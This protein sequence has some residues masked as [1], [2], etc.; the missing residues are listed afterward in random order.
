MNMPI[1]EFNV[2]LNNK[3]RT[4]D[5]FNINILQYCSINNINIPRFCFHETLSIAGNCRMCLVEITGN[6][7][8]IA[9]CAVL[10]QK[11]MSIHTDTK[12][13]KKAREGVL[14]FLLINHPLDCPICDQGG[15][16]DLQDQTL[17][18]GNDKGRF[19]DFK[20]SIKDKFCGYFIKTIMT[21]CI[22]CTRCVRFLFEIAGVINFGMIGRGNTIE[23]SQYIY[24]SINSELSGNI[25]DL[26][27]VGALTSK[28]YAFVARSWELF[29]L[30]TIDIQ[31]T[32]HVNI[33]LDLR[34]HRILRVLPCYIKDLNDNFISDL[35]RFSYDGFYSNRIQNPLVKNVKKGS[36][37]KSTWL[38][39][40]KTLK[41]M[42]FKKINCFLG[43]FLDSETCILLKFFLNSFG[44]YSLNLTD[45]F[46]QNLNCDFRHNFI[47]NNSII[48]DV[49]NSSLIVLFINNLRVE[50]PILNMKLKKLVKVRDLKIFTLGNNFNYN[51]FHFNLG[52]SLK[53]FKN[54]SE[55]K[56][57]LSNLIIKNIHP[58]YFLFD[59]KF[60][61]YFFN[62]DGVFFLFNFFKKFNIYSYVLN[63]S[64][65]NLLSNEFN[66]KNTINSFNDLSFKKIIYVDDLVYF[67][68]TDSTV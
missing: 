24:K 33:R 13:V 2:F 9:A 60:L 17:I 48:N 11:G 23:I 68:N 50:N 4:S 26:C 56:N 44:N 12:L 18:Y 3:P 22:Q 28:P 65:T 38:F 42:C 66:L 35:T 46:F 45:I 15:E 55:G 62:S 14:E 7:K 43:N 37:L 59:Y 1:K 54:I 32:Y 27:P 10:L 47:I 67:L 39:I 52:N 30:H 41:T 8:P 16:C 53:I 19:Y 57:F 49:F 6:L 58:I 29:F 34:D 31:D 25:I 61:N 63:F 5:N 64:S 21:R 20:R 40:L 36:F 51:F